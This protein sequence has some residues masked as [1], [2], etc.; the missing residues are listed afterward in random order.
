M[1]FKYLDNGDIIFTKG[2]PPPKSEPSGY[3]RDADDPYLFHPDYEPC[4]WRTLR[5]ERRRCGRIIIRHYCELYE[6]IVTPDIC[7]E[8]DETG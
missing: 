2:L 7:E 5:S 1:K 4:K 3:E 6:K 8:C